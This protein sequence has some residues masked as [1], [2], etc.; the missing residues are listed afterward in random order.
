MLCHSE[1][2]QGGLWILFRMVLL[3]Q[4]GAYI[5]LFIAAL[6]SIVYVHSSFESNPLISSP[7]T[8]S[9]L[10]LIHT[11][12]EISL[13]EHERA[14][15]SKSISCSSHWPRQ[16]CSSVSNGHNVS[17]GFASKSKPSSSTMTTILLSSTERLDTLTRNG[18]RRRFT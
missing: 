12:S 9:Y 10:I 7:S 18:Y 11:P 2:I 3:V 14:Q 1:S 5:V 13:T 6:H 16:L 8:P 4:T 15:A 17:S